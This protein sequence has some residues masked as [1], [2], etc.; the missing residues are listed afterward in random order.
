MSIFLYV[1]LFSQQWGM[2]GYLN[3][4][5][6]LCFSLFKCHR[7]VIIKFVINPFIFTYCM[8]CP[9]ITSKVDLGL[10][11]MSWIKF[12]NIDLILGQ[13]LDLFKFHFH[14]NFKLKKFKIGSDV[15][16][17][18]NKLLLIEFSVIQTGV[19]GGFCRF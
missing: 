19:E 11:L 18:H 14:Q 1:N 2:R 10:G 13:N 6:K 12:W 9:W 8:F 7:V 4:R 5:I 15:D 3:N 17:R 16:G